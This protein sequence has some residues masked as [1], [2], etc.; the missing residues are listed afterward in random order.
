M[1]NYREADQVFFVQIINK[2]NFYQV[3][4]QRKVQLMFS[5]FQKILFC[6]FTEFDVD[7]V[8]NLRLNRRIVWNIL[9]SQERH[10][11]HLFPFTRKDC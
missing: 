4:A 2:M 11:I 8:A 6:F 9:D 5:C 10:C 7:T 3:C 1:D